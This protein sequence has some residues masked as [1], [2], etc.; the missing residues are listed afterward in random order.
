MEDVEHLD[1]KQ[2]LGRTKGPKDGRLHVCV[3]LYLV[4]CMHVCVCLYLTVCVQLC[5][6]VCAHV[7]IY[8]PVLDLTRLADEQAQGAS[9]LSPLCPTLTW[10]LGI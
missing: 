9:C 4:V 3:C 10:F 5:V 1:E 8:R 6:F 7:C 2:I